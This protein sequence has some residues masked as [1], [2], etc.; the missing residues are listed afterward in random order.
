MNYQRHRKNNPALLKLQEEQRAIKDKALKAKAKADS[1][2]EKLNIEQKS[3][4]NLA[5]KAQLIQKEHEKAKKLEDAGEV[6]S[7]ATGNKAPVSK[8]LDLKNEKAVKKVIK[9]ALK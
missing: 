2:V 7:S 5:A 9:K 3:Q 8:K 1:L 6:V 4:S